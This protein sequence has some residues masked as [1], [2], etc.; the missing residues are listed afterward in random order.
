MDE[1]GQFLTALVSEG[2]TLGVWP[3][4]PN[5]VFKA[6]QVLAVELGGAKTAFTISK[7][8]EGK[9]ERPV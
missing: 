9:A 1:L 2:G 8:I 5:S 3:I 7:G 4:E 6:L